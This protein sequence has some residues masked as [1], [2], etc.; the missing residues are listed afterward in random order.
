MQ[1][2]GQKGGGGG[3]GDGAT[4]AGKVSEDAITPKSVDFS[5]WYLDLVAK[6]QLADYG[7][8]RGEQQG[9]GMRV[10][11]RGSCWGGREEDGEEDRMDNIIVN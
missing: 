1:G 4:A 11:D 5:K 8:V 7:P 3:G 9:C 10:W 6:A 2:K